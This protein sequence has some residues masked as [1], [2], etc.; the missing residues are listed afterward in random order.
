MERAED[1]TANRSRIR[2]SEAF[3]I[4][5]QLVQI[6][7]IGPRGHYIRLRKERAEPSIYGL[8]FDHGNTSI[9]TYFHFHIIG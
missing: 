1:T 4:Y 8:M 3:N 6:S 2:I 7:C 9:F 5:I